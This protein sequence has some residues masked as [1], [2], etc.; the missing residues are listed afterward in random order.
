MADRQVQAM[1]DSKP[2]TVLV[3]GDRNWTD[4]RAIEAA[5]RDCKPLVVIH[6]AARGADTL[7]GRAARHLRLIEYPMPAD[8]D[9]HGR[10]A[11]PIRNRAMLDLEP[12]LVLAFH[13]N[14]DA[15]KG[16]RGCVTEARRRGIPTRVWNGTAWDC[17]AGFDTGRGA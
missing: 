3:C 11:G 12:D 10:S 1:A 13:E 16:T 17:G 4:W 5:L 7:A 2:M 15:S 14:L 8:W 9:K 6:G